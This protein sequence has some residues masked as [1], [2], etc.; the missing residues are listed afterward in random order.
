MR[1]ERMLLATAFLLGALLRLP[2][3][4]ATPLRPDEASQAWRA[5]QAAS[6]G[7]IVTD[8]VASAFLASA[9]AALFLLVE[10]NTLLARLPAALCGL[11]LLAA[12]IVV[13]D[14]LG[15]ARTLALVLLLAIDPTLVRTAR[16][17]SGPAAAVLAAALAAVSIL[18]WSQAARVD[19]ARA[20][21][22]AV[23]TAAA[24]GILATTGPHA[25]TLALPLAL[26]ATTLRPWRLSAPRWRTCAA[27]FFGSLLLAATAGLWALPWAAAVSSSL[28]M[29]LGW[30]ASPSQATV[31][32]AVVRSAPLTALLA[33]LGVAHASRGRLALMGAL[34]WGLLAA[35]RSDDGAAVL[36]VVLAW[37]AS[38]AMGRA[39][40]DDRARRAWRVALAAAPLA[41]VV[42]LGAAARPLGPGSS[43]SAR[44]DLDTLAADLERLA[45]HEGREATEMPAFVLGEREDPGVLW[46]LRR[47]RAVRYAPH[48]PTGSDGTRPALVLTGAMPST[49][50]AGYVGTTYGAP[51]GIVSLWVP[52]D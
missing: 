7:Q 40:E 37:S 39:L 26:V 31:P 18:R 16:D 23:A 48:R 34:A 12:P 44:P 21:R 32:L 50:P 10:P 45:V 38:A 25:W 49:P 51:S 19:A 1:H 22:C 42:Q 5:G 24:A 9:Q 2:G 33:M 43:V 29:W 11:A 4:D 3:I 6:Q 27:A 35:F 41:L 20:Q 46:A 17:G 52:I 28:T 15:P 36:A 8:G 14:V 47:A 13:R 30:A